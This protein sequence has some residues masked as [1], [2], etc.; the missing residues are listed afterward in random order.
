MA[1]RK[2]TSIIVKITIVVLL[3]LVNQIIFLTKVQYKCTE[4]INEGKDLNVYE[5][6]SAYQ[7]HTNLWLFGWVIEPNTAELC[8]CKQF[9]IKQP[10]HLYNLPKEDSYLKSVRANYT[11]PVRLAWKTYSSKASIYLNGSTVTKRYD[12]DG[13]YEYFEYSIPADYSPGIIQIKGIAL[14]ETV[15]DY[16]EQKGWL[17]VFTD[18]RLVF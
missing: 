15:F 17:C 4:K 18:Q 9:H 10:I 16:L 5:L 13:Q 2:T 3:L 12:E 8:F 14:S 6:L 11:K 1:L 7:T